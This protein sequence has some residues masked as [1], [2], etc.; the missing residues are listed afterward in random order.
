MNSDINFTENADHV[1]Y[2]LQIANLDTTSSLSEYV[3][4][5]KTTIARLKIPVFNISCLSNRRH[6]T[7]T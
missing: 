6:R 5:L 4:N 1:K 7:S 3:N 2:L